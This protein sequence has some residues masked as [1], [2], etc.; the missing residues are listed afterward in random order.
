MHSCDIAMVTSIAHD[1][2][3]RD[4]SYASTHMPCRWHKRDVT[5]AIGHRSVIVG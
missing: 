5:I 3:D 4:V 2:D 1:R